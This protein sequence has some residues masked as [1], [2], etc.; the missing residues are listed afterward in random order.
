MPAP[1]SIPAQAQPHFPAPAPLPSAQAP[2]AA[3]S[4]DM[5]A[6]MAVLSNQAADL[7]PLRKL[8][9]AGAAAQIARRAL[10]KGKIS[11]PAELL[12][13]LN[14]PNGRSIIINGKRRTGKSNLALALAE[15]LAGFD[16]DVLL[17]LTHEP[18][19]RLSDAY[20]WL[21]EKRAEDFLLF[22]RP[23]T[24]DAILQPPSGDPAAARQRLVDA[25]RQVR[26]D[27]S[28]SA[29]P[30]VLERPRSFKINTE[31][32]SRLLSLNPAM[33]E[34]INLYDAVERLLPSKVVIVVDRADSLARKYGIEYKSLVETLQRDLVRGA[35]CD[36]IIVQERDDQH[37]A[38]KSVDGVIV[39]RDISRT[40]EFLGEL[41][42][43]NLT[44]V[45]LKRPRAL[46][47]FDEGRIR[48]IESADVGSGM[49]GE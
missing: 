6:R 18:E 11:L 48:M 14:K 37:S 43:A 34:V 30:R 5:M 17:L 12:N 39:M 28:S 36:L 42:I 20:A 31:R 46:Y 8:D 45:V 16:E 32:I 4:Q 23:N 40:E 19:K 47:R 3:P 26:G 49:D 41:A 44:D 22:G 15:A 7:A 10:A 2:A 27:P 9:D 13:Y 35:N 29:L 25:V 24:P 33:A 1:G 21:A 38:D